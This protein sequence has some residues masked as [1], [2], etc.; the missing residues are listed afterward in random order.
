VRDSI[1]RQPRKRTTATTAGT[2]SQPVAKRARRCPSI[3]P[4]TTISCATDD[5]NSL[6][7]EFRVYI[8]VTFYDDSVNGASFSQLMSTRRQRLTIPVS[9]TAAAKRTRAYQKAAV[10]ATQTVSASAVPV[11]IPADDQV[12]PSSAPIRLIQTNTGLSLHLAS[13][14]TEGQMPSTFRRSITLLLTPTDGRP[15]IT[16][17]ITTTDP[18]PDHGLM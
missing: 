15:P 2:S 6:Q 18:E 4:A 8:P 3:H 7:N 5:G 13:T 11:H 16:V 17:V 12:F 14:P 1:T 10:V 9:S